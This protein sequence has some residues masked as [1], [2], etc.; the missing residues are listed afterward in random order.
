MRTQRQRNV[1]YLFGAEFVGCAHAVHLAQPLFDVDFAF[2]I[3]RQRRNL[4]QTL[5]QIV[6]QRINLVDGMQVELE[7]ILHAVAVRQ[8]TSG[9][10]AIARA[11]LR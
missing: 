6:E 7:R 2:P 8:A 11:P 4:A 9:E 3:W 10:T 1:A 5:I